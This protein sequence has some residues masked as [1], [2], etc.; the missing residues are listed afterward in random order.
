[1][2]LMKFVDHGKMS[3]LQISSTDHIVPFRIWGAPLEI[4][5]NSNYEALE[6]VCGNRK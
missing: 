5:L 3:G 2:R 6:E 4:L 1:M